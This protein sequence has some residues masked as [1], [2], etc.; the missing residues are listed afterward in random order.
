[1]IENYI[2]SGIGHALGKFTITNEDLEFAV[3]KGY[4]KG[5]NEDRLRESEAYKEFAKDHPGVSPFQYL[6]EYKMGFRTRNHVVPFPPTKT[7][8][9]VADNTVHLGVQAVQ[10]AL[11]DAGIHPEEIDAWFVSTATPHEQAP[12]LGATLKCYFVN[13]SNQTPTTTVTS[14]CVGVN[15]NIQRSIEYFKCH[16]EAKHIVVAHSE[17]M[18]AILQRKTDFVP[19]VTF[20]DAAAAIIFSRV[21]SDKKEGVSSIV[22]HEDLYMIDFLGANKQG[23]LYMDAGVVKY[24][25][26]KNILSSS[27]ESLDKAGWTLQDIDLMVPHQ[28]GHAIVHGAAEKMEFPL[29]K[30]FQEVQLNH[31]NLSGASIPLGIS[32]LKKSGRLK[33]GMKILTATAGLGGEFGSYTY[34]VQDSINSKNTA[35]KSNDLKGKTALVTGCS[36]AIGVEIAK[37][38]TMLGCKLIL[39]YNSAEE[40]KAS[41]ETFLQESN[42]DYSFYQADFKD[43]K[44]VD[45][46]ISN[47]K[48]DHTKIDYLVHAA[49]NTGNSSRSSEVSDEETKE[50]AQVNQYAPAEISKKLMSTISSAILYVGSVAEEAQFPGLSAYIQSKCGLHGFAANFANELASKKIRSIYYMP[51]ITDGGMADL[52]DD[53]QKYN[54]MLSIGQEDIVP[55]C[56]VAKRIVRSL[57]IPKVLKVSDKYEGA[58]LVRRD[59]YMI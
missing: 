39:Q 2:F 30:V 37:E 41:L 5:F 20:A 22:N 35:N 7:K 27:K 19:F 12:G 16:P 6:A 45:G 47:I 36:G 10:N 21:S 18:S 52:L 43:A 9:K 3:K 59:G 26:I 8:L 49:A 14:A 48:K 31:G 42:A 23:D 46:F 54:A 32:L 57:Y 40:K 1:M 53:K 50:I 56:E 24:R 29:E 28:T 13:H 33:P 15:I 4:L 11:N 34:L 44:S 25:A 51:G 17:V 38:L 55:I 58:L